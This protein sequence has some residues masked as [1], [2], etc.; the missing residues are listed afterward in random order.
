VHREPGHFDRLVAELV[1]RFLI[2][3]D[4]GV[5]FHIVG[6]AQIQLELASAVHRKWEDID[7][8]A[9]HIAHVGGMTV[10]CFWGIHMP[11]WLGLGPVV[12]MLVL[13]LE[14]LVLVASMELGLVPHAV[15]GMAQKLVG[16]V[17]MRIVDHTEDPHGML[18]E[19]D[20]YTLLVLVVLS[21][22]LA[23]ALDLVS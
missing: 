2:V 21:R 12:V 14:A 15:T 6:L 5:G 18:E 20:L 22:A 7:L 13:E 4:L 17:A 23:L 3:H 8:R 1:S 16:L 19:A 10:L 9:Q 11:A